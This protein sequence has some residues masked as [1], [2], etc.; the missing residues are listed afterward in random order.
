MSSLRPWS[1]NIGFIYIDV[2]MVNVKGALSAFF[3]SE[4]KCAPIAFKAVVKN[5]SC[6]WLEWFPG[7]CKKECCFALTNARFL[8]VLVF[9]R[10]SR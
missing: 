8:W 2:S 3:V 5:E 1:R 7:V 10:T 4:R 9:I 6:L